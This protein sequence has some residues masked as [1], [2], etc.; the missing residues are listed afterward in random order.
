MIEFFNILFQIVLYFGIVAIIAYFVYPLHDNIEKY[1]QHKV[2]WITGASSGIGRE[3]AKELVRL[4]PTTRLIISARREE[5]LHSLAKELNLDS[6]HCLVLPLDLESHTHGFQSKVDLVLDRFKR[7]D[8]LINNAG[9]SQRSLI[10]DTIYQVDSRLMNI[11]YLGT[12]TLSKAV[13]PHFMERQ[14]GHYVVVTSAT[15]YVG[16]PLRSSYAAS[17]HALHGF[18]DSLRLEHT[19]DHIDVTMVCPGFVKTDVSINAFEGSG[20]LHR[21]MDPQTEKGTDPIVC[22]NNILHGVAARKHEIYVGRSA[23][24]VIYLQRFFPKILYQVLLRIDSS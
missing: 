17:K 9:I 1:F 5:E 15:G 2:V 23:A 20:R 6:D 21:K 3:L 4:S 18:F 13:L 10:K 24:I 11:N 8:V 22:A 19:R 14:S 16:T 7:I 12:V